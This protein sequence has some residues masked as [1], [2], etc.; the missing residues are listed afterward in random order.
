MPRKLGDFNNDNAVTGADATAILRYLDQ[1]SMCRP[2]DPARSEE[3]LEAGD[4]MRNERLSSQDSAAILRYYSIDSTMVRAY[5]K[6][7]PA[8]W[9]DSG[10]DGYKKYFYIDPETGE[11]VSLAN[12][13][14]APTFVAKKY[15]YKTTG[16]TGILGDDALASLVTHLP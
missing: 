5:P 6:T 12:D 11:E 9:T 4:I 1:A 8:N 7:Q 10:V 2:I 16:V 3:D 15:Y 13:P 14:T